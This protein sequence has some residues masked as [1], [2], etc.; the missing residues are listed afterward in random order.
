MRKTVLMVTMLAAPLALGGC[1]PAG[2]TT[3]DASAAPSDVASD[4]SGAA[5]DAAM[6]P[7]DAPSTDATGDKPS[8]SSG[9]NP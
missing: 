3:A 2:N 6:A 5:S 8:S 7:S 4:A 1:Q 9:P